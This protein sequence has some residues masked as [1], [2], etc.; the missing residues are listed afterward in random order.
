MTQPRSPDWLTQVFAN[1]SQRIAELPKVLRDREWPSA[2]NR[3]DAANA[4]RTDSKQR[5]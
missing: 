5:A 4:S 3:R 2:Q 1:N